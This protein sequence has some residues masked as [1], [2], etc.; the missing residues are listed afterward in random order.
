MHGSS[1]LISTASKPE[2][3]ERCEQASSS[4][5]STGTPV[6]HSEPVDQLQAVLATDLQNGFCDVVI[7]THWM[8][9]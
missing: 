9:D 5:P 2:I 3:I 4:R 7:M 8:T 1:N 6:A